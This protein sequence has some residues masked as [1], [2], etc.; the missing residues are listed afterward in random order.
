M[1]ILTLLTMLFCALFVSAQTFPVDFESGTEVFEDFDGGASSVI[2]NPQSSGINTSAKVAQLVKG[3]GETWAGNK[4]IRTNAIDFTTNQ[5]FT[6]K[7]YSPKVGVNVLFKL[8]KDG[9]YTVAQER[10]VATTVANQWETLTYDFSGSASDL[11]SHITI[12]FDNGTAGDG[13]ADWTFL[14]DDIEFSASS[15]PALA[16]PIDFEGGP[17]LFTDYDGGAATVIANPQSLGENTSATVAQ[18]VRDGG[19]T[20]AGSKL[21]LNDK[22]DF[23]TASTFSMKVY[24]SR[25]GVPVLFKLEGDAQTELSTNTTVA[26]QWETLTWDFTGQPSNTFNTLALMFDF[27]TVGD[28]S[29]NSIFLFDDIQIIDAT[30]GLSQIDLPVTFDDE[31]INYT[32]T[33]F[34]DNSTVL[35]ADPTDANNMVA[36]TTKPASAATWAG[37]T[38]GTALGF[39]NAAPFTETETFISV[40]VYSPSIGSVIRLKGESSND[41]TLT[42]ET[43]QTTTVAN[44]WET[45]VFDFSNVAAGTN[46]FNLATAFDKF[47][48]FFEFNTNGAESTYYWDDV[49]FGSDAAALNTVKAM[50]ALSVYPNPTTGTL[51]IVAADGSLVS[52][53]NVTGQLQKQ[54]ILHAGQISLEELNAGIYFVTA[55][56]KMSRVIKK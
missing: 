1:K 54:E 24:S 31:T 55:G 43:E 28:G 50:D 13:S 37:T 10:V 17:Y 35:G 38:I 29:A 42:A 22:I 2:A 6:M 7:V 47:S 45:L 48:I 51:N 41:V 3:A 33:D 9:D 19:A 16:L 34:G 15:A 32:L 20:W 25:V 27:G 52:V 46:P 18:M 49:M 23:S 14:I 12:I 36:I 8:E 21:I 11:Y 56:N 26:N 44:A 4:I 40:K 53:Y 39:K 5:V 30:G